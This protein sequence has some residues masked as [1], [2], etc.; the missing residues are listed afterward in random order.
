M[1][2]EGCAP[3]LPAPPRPWE[4]MPEEEWVRSVDLRWGLVLAVFAESGLREDAILKVLEMWVFSECGIVRE[5]EE[6][7]CR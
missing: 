7:D 1:L 3:K 6:E 2:S 4:V 5:E